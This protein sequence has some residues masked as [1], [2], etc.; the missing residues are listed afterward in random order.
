[1][2]ILS[3]LD[4]LNKP[5]VKD[6]LEETARLYFTSDTVTINLVWSAIILG[7]IGLA[8]K[9]IFGIPLL[10][11]IL[12]AMSGGSSGGYGGSGY[13]APSGGYGAPS[14]GYGAPS[15]G[16]GAP[17]AGYG[18]P[19]TGYDSPSS[20]YDSPSSG[21]D[22]PAAGG[23]GSGFNP[24]SDY[25]APSSGYSAGR[26]KRDILSEDQKEFYT[27]LAKNFEV[28]VSPVIGSLASDYTNLASNEYDRL[29]PVN[30]IPGMLEQ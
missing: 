10:E 25:S 13:G 14:G 16:Y 24:G 17:D 27:N 26:R 29:T 23:S 28:G 30:P 11:N 7:L 9:P 12:G 15:A 22:T 18:A 3:V 1:M 20:G 5:E 19:S 21:Y 2:D 6:G 8:L 4:F